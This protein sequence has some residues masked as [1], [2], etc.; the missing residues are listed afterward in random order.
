MGLDLDISFGT[1]PSMDGI[2][3]INIYSK[4]QTWLGRWLSNFQYAPFTHETHG[5]F[6]SIEG[7]WYWLKTGLCHDTLRTLSGWEAKKEGRKFQAVPL[8][9]FEFHVKYALYLKLIQNPEAIQPLMK[10]RLPFNHYYVVD[11]KMVTVSGGEFV[12]EE[13]ETI[14]RLLL[15]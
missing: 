1:D 7:Y 2:D 12:I 9:S 10:S 3:H 5:S 14:R 4:G 6:H 8:G 13:W 15:G 11:G